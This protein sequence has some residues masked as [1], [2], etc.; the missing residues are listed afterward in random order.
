MPLESGLFVDL[1]GTVLGN[2]ADT[3]VLQPGDALPQPQVLGLGGA[4]KVMPQ[5]MPIPRGVVAEYEVVVEA[6][7]SIVGRPESFMIVR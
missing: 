2:Q 5:L 3:L 1:T 6:N 7:P 4:F